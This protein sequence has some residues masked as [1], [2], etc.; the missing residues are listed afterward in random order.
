MRNSFLPILFVPLSFR[1]V[2]YHEI[3]LYLFITKL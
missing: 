3:Q 1:D 2:N